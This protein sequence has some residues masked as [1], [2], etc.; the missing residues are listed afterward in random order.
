MRLVLLVVLVGCVS[1]DYELEDTGR[2]CAASAPDVGTV[3]LMVFER[4]KPLFL[5]V[6]AQVT[7]AGCPIDVEGT[8]RTQEV[9][10]SV[11]VVNA[12]LTWNEGG[13]CT[14]ELQ[15]VRAACNVPSVRDDTLLLFGDQMLEIGVPSR[16]M[17]PCVGE[18][19]ER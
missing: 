3:G 15:Y 12:H 5:S 10:P 14:R 4:D 1:K 13:A 2:L 17:D 7:G 16:T 8:C 9:T 19:A 11:F 6:T 18:L